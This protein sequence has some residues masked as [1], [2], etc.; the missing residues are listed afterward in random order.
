MRLGNSECTAQR[1]LPRRQA[2]TLRCMPH[3]P[4]LA[5]LFAALFSVG[6]HAQTQTYQLDPVHTQVVFSIDHNG[7]SRSIGRAPVINGVLHLDEKNLAAASVSLDIDLTR[8]DMGN[9]DWNKAV[10]ASGLLNTDAYPKAH[11]ESTSVEPKDAQGGTIHGQ[12]TLHGVTRPLDITFHVNRVARTIYGMHTVAGISAS[13]VLDRND[14]GIKAN[15]G[16]IGSTVNFWLEVEAIRG[17]PDPRTQEQ[18]HAAAQ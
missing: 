8:V 18:D 12:L 7:Y 6:A 5:C 10:R 14:F 2:G 1:W 17:E 16:S 9:A 15:A 4:L 3:R 13:A 11:F